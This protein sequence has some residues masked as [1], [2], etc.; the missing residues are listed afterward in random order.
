MIGWLNGMVLEKRPPTLLLNVQ[1]VGYEL[2]AP[3]TTFY[4]LPEVGREVNIY[5][6]HLVREDAQNLY[7]FSRESERNVFRLLL[8]VNGVGAKVAL[9]ILSGMDAPV[10]AECLYRGD[11]DSLSKIPG[12]GK[13]TAER[14]VIEMRDR[15]PRAETASSTGGSYPAV[16]SNPVG[17][18]V[19]E[20]VAAMAALGYKPAEAGKRVA[21]V[22]QEGMACEEIVREALKNVVRAF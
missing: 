20:A 6:H 21:A 13:K 2:E 19:G 7:A 16:A 15:L 4:D 5:V 22:A 1:G 11:T 18:P 14:L 12:I 8:K 9:A 10:L 17:D 3:M